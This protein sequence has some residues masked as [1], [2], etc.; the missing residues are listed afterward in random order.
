MLRGSQ[1]P[2]SAEVLQSGEELTYNVSYAGIDIGQIRFRILSVTPEN[3]ANA[4]HARSLMDSY[5]G[6]PF[7]NLHT[8]YETHMSRSGH[9]AWFLSRNKDDD[10]WVARVYNY[11]Y[12]KGKV[13]VEKGIWKNPVIEERDTILVDTFYQDGLSLFFFARQ[14]L[15]PGAHYSVPSLVGENKGRTEIDVGIQPTH[16]SIDAI[17]YPVSV[18]HCEGEAGFVGVFGFTGHFEGWFSNDNAHVPILAKLKVLIGTVRVE[19]MKWRRTGWNPPKYT[20]KEQ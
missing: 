1:A 2:D 6:I 13:I 18:L 16:E 17:D 15:V 3:E 14:H 11:D 10:Q 8:A 7:V 9:S 12:P 19:L 5:K 4:C 20:E